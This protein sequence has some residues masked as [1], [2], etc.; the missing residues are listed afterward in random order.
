[1]VPMTIDVNN[2]SKGEKDQ[3]LDALRPKSKWVPTENSDKAFPQFRCV[4]C[5]LIQ[6][7]L[8]N[9]CEECGS[10]MQES[11]GNGKYY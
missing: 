7:Y 8:S 2:L 10:D 9:F 3:L 11:N 5:G 4:R 1:M 6:N